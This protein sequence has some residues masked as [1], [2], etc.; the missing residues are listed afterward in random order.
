M[1][2]LG[3]GGF[4]RVFQSRFLIPFL[5]FPMNNP[6][7]ILWEDCFSQIVQSSAQ[8]VSLSYTVQMQSWISNQSE[9]SNIGALPM[10]N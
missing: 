6:R 5:I 4:C 10:V 9:D 1:D 8:N 3:V 7:L 2:R